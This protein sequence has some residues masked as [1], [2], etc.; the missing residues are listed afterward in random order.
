M[1]LPNFE[2]AIVAYEK[3][4]GYLLNPERP[5]GGDKC[6][7]FIRFGFSVAQWEVLASALIDHATR[8][9]VVKTEVTK[10]GTRYVVEGPVKSP[11]KRNPDVRSVWFIRNDE[12]FP[13]L[14]TAYRLRG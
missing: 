7:F 10:Y 9:E 5:E 6:A 14:V 1:S 4:A 13:R 8:N 3:I 11:D 2:H 12:K